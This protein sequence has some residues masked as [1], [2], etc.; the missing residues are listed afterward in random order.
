MRRGVPC[1]SMPSDLDRVDVEHGRNH[2]ILQVDDLFRYLPVNS[3]THEGVMV[4]A[5]ECV[6]LAKAWVVDIDM[7]DR[8]SAGSVLIRIFD[9]YIADNV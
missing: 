7:E 3:F 1:L 4:A 8:A 5:E 6:G 2:L 9:N